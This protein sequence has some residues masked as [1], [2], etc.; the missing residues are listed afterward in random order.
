MKSTRRV[1]LSSILMG[2]LIWLLDAAADYW[3]FYRG[4]TFFDLLVASPP[5]HELYIRILILTVFICFGAVVARR[6][7]REREVSRRLKRAVRDKEILLREVH[8]RVKNNLSVILSL[9]KL[10]IDARASESGALDELY[11]R[12]NSI[13]LIHN[14]L[15]Q[16]ENLEAVE[17]DRYLS[18]LT[19]EILGLY[20]SD[21]RTVTAHKSLESM[22]ASLD[23]AVP[24]G[25][26][27][28]ELIQNACK[29]AFAGRDEGKLSV[30]LRRD[31]GEFAIEVSD[32]GRGASPEPSADEGT[33]TMG[34]TLVQAL[35]QQLGA[36]L[37][38]YIGNGVSVILTV[39]IDKSNG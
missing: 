7:R 5:P 20:I 13:A 12:V 23:V 21:E 30:T 26:I 33:P 2:L 1:L 36:R 19:D 38:R 8:H 24:C 37:E 11:A 6:L 14:H 25:L 15:Y 9:I 35:A 16:G 28:S 4:E 31:T 22:T 29:H 34:N 10:E 3:F 17:L 39:P 32:D 18:E 27:F